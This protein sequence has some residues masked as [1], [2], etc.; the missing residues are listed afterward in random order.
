MREAIA[1]IGLLFGP[2]LVLMGSFFLLADITIR[3]RIFRLFSNLTSWTS[4]GSWILTLF[5][6]SGLAYALIF[7]RPFQWLPWGNMS[8][9]SMVIGSIAA[10]FSILVLIYP[11]FLLG[12]T[13]AIPFW[14]TPLLTLLFLLSGL[15]SGVASLMLVTPLFEETLEYGRVHFIHILGGAAAILVFLEIIALYAYLEVAAHGSVASK[16]SIRLLK[17]S[18]FN[19][20]MFI[21]GLL[22]PFALLLCG[23]FIKETLLLSRLSIAAAILLLA[24]GFY[25]R[26]AIIHAG[27]FIPRFSI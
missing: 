1:R 14:N 7:F 26:Y 10:L 3:T 21:I 23:I 16:E 4:R 15:C 6:I 18:Q 5:I 11:G 9:L 20:K 22:L 2:F 17:A 12:M 25:L 27:V 13:N 19:L 8:T 24:G